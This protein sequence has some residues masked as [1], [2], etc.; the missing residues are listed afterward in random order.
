MGYHRTPFRSALVRVVIVFCLCFYW[1]HCQ[2]EYMYICAFVVLFTFGVCLNVA[3][4]V[5]TPLPHLNTL[6]SL[7]PSTSVAGT[8]TFSQG[9][10]LCVWVFFC[11]CVN[12]GFSYPRLHRFHLCVSCTFPDLRVPIEL[13]TG[14][15]SDCNLDLQGHLAHHTDVAIQIYARHPWE[16]G[17]GDIQSNK[18][19]FNH[20]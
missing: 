11:E 8:S 17:S 3:C 15:W 1:Y 18:V 14:S 12:T 20:P 10:L 9:T 19:I 13:N 4:L 16:R 6:A 2:W 7:S 5:Q